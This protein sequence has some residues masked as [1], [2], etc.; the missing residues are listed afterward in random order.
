MDALQFQLADGSVEQEFSSRLDNNLDETVIVKSG[1]IVSLARDG[2]SI[3]L[4]PDANPSLTWIGTKSFDLGSNLPAGE[5]VFS[6]MGKR[7]RLTR[8]GELAFA[9]LV[10]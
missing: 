9:E 5:G 7:Y 8:V 1:K 3:A 10:P 2:V 4:I 6:A